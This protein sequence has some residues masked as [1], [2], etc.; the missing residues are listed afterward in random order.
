MFNRFRNSILICLALVVVSFGAQQPK[1]EKFAH[2]VERSR[3]AGRIVPLLTVNPEEGIPKELLDKSSAIGIFPKVE[4]ETIYFTHMIHGYGVISTRRS[5]GW[6]MPA[7]YQFSGA[8]YGKPFS[9]KDKYAVILLF[10]GDEALDAFD[11]GGVRLN[12]EKQTAAGPVGTITEA[13]RK[14]LAG[15]QVIAYAYYNG[16]LKGTEYN[17]RFALNPDNNINTPMYGVKGR[18][19]LA[20][21]QPTAEVPEGIASYRDALRNYSAK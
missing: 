9:D 2:A 18:E 1:D 15:S 20:G 11:K 6:T 14:E 21:K 17:S 7:F 12:N 5:D 19:I 13:Q 10:L 3:D 16:K 4:R 8:G